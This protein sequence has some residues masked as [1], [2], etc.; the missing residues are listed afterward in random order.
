MKRNTSMIAQSW[1][2]W[3]FEFYYLPSTAALSIWLDLSNLV[4]PYSSM[5]FLRKKLLTVSVNIE[6]PELTLY[7]GSAPQP[8]LRKT[9]NEV[10]TSYVLLKYMFALKRH[11]MRSQKRIRDVI[12]KYKHAHTFYTS[13]KHAIRYFLC[14]WSYEYVWEITRLMNCLILYIVLL[15]S[16]L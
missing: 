10:S 12:R 2:C 15:S 8:C 3:N 11:L 4:I 9:I 7:K 16:P 6:F 5:T 1:F 13:Y 14:S